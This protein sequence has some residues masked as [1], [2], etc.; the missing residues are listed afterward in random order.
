MDSFKDGCFCRPEDKIYLM[1]YSL[2]A[3][4][5]RHLP[6]TRIKLT[7]ASLLYTIIRLYKKTDHVTVTRKGVNYRLDLTEGIDLSVFIFGF[8]QKHIIQQ[9]LKCP[10]DSVVLDIGANMGS[11]SLGYAK[12]STIGHVYA[13]EPT[14]YG[15]N[16]LLK[17]IALNPDLTSRIT[18]V[19]RFVSDF[20][21]DNHTLTASASWKLT[22]TEL[23]RHPVHG[24]IQSPSDAPCISVDTFCENRNISQVDL[25]KIDTDGHELPVLKGALQTLRSHKP[26]IVFETGHYIMKEHGIRFNDYSDLLTQE[27]YRL[28]SLHHGREITL[29]N[30]SRLIPGRSTIDIIGIHPLKHRSIH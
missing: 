20:S 12:T 5:T 23:I 29:E 30:A 2:T 16:R 11:M 26:V 4:V 7:I 27:G 19:K 3:P 15:F 17:N 10:A 1:I 6:L 21:A 9:A 22:P 14:D 28:F 18:P 24:G 25:I 13:F 8:F